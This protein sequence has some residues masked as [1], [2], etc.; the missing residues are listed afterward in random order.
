MTVSGSGCILDLGMDMV[1]NPSGPYSNGSFYAV[2]VISSTKTSFNLSA[3][4]S[5]FTEDSQ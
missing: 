4:Y 5:Y 2:L 1:S 3:F